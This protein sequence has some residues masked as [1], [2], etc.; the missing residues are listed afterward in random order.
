MRRH[1]FNMAPQREPFHETCRYSHLTPQQNLDHALPTPPPH[2]A[3]ITLGN[4][5]FLLKWAHPSL[6]SSSI[7]AKTSFLP[8]KHLSGTPSSTLLFS[9]YDWL[10]SSCSSSESDVTMKSCSTSENCQPTWN[11]YF[12]QQ[13]K[14]VPCLEKLSGH[15]LDGGLTWNL[16]KIIYMKRIRQVKDLCSRTRAFNLLPSPM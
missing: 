11:V 9:V 5:W 15:D 12:Y 8:L 13:S 16:N 6:N 10:S 14:S 3:R 1:C 4:I 2:P 7:M